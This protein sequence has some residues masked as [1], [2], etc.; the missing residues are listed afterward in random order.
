MFVDKR[1]AALKESGDLLNAIKAGLVSASHI[2][3]ELGEVI[4]RR[5]PGR[6]SREEFTLYKSLGLGTQDLA[7]IEAATHSARSKGCGVEVKW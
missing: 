3:A 7:A 2:Q 4:A 1:E 6:N 5:H